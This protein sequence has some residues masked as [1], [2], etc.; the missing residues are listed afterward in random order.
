MRVL[1]IISVSP[2]WRAFKR[3]GRLKMACQL[4]RWW[5]AWLGFRAMASV[6]LHFLIVSRD[7]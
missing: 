1:G 7:S 3:S 2:A 6:L 5:L 4:L